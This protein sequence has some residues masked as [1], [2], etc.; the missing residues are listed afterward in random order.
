MLPSMVK[1]SSRALGNIQPAV[2]P[3]A[4][5]VPLGRTNW[6]CIVCVH[7]DWA[8]SQQWRGQHS[9]CT[10]RSTVVNIGTLTLR[11]FA[12]YRQN[13]FMYFM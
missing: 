8:M 4:R 12:L 10:L 13:V 11:K 5:P 1:I 9:F 3:L 7:I 2:L 6:S